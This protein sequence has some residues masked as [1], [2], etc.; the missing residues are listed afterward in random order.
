M[1]VNY[2][3]AIARDKDGWPTQAIVMPGDGFA[4]CFDPAFWQPGQ[5]GSAYKPYEPDPDCPVGAPHCSKGVN[6][7]EHYLCGDCTHEPCPEHGPQPGA[8]A[9]EDGLRIA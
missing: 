3:V 9:L 5:P 4:D 1:S 2:P 7:P 6:D 8:I